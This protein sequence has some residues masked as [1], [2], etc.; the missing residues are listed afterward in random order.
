MTEN[1]KK[2]TG[3]DYL[4]ISV[5]DRCNLKC[6]YCMPCENVKFI[7][8]HDILTYEEIIELTEIAVELGVNKV[9]ITGG[10]PLIKTDIRFLI[11]KL[12][13]IKGILELAITTNGT[14]LENNLDFLYESGVKKIN[15]S[16]DTLNK[17]KYAKLTG[18]DFLNR[19]LKSIKKSQEY[20]FNKIKLN[21][22]VINN[23][24]DDEILD[25]VQLTKNNNIVV[26]FI[27]HMPIGISSGKANKVLYSKEIINRIE[28]KYSIKNL[29]KNNP[30]TSSTEYIVHGHIGKIGFISSV[31][32]NFCNS[33]K[34]LRLT[35]DGR[36]KSCLMQNFEVDVKTPLRKGAKK[37]ELIKYFK[38]AVDKKQYLSFKNSDSDKL[39]EMFQVGG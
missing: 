13:S 3:V 32:N 2:I 30:G 18:Y 34:R 24:N 17:E 5:T 19:V 9:R 7:P 27:E 39:R 20:G 23:F 22:V 28:K 37:A 29:N 21:T 4:R 10:E 12:A 8:K 38:M 16:L 31:S 15:I 25:F 14:M 36:L 26:R 35:A 1:K 6:S 11:S 33:C